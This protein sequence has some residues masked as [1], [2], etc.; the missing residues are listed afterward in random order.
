MNSLALLTFVQ[1]AKLS[2]SSDALPNHRVYQHTDCLLA[3]NLNRK[4]Y[5]GRHIVS[6]RLHMGSQYSS[7]GAV[8]R[9]ENQRDRKHKFTQTAHVQ[10]LANNMAAGLRL[11][12]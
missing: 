8:Y 9:T 10:V 1:E 7:L 2:V 3:K 6:K 11:S 4:S 5:A 12:I